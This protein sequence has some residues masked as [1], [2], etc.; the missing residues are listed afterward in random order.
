[1]KCS[2]VMSAASLRTMVTAM[3]TWI[4]G[5]LEVADEFGTAFVYA[6]LN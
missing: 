1:V 3:L 5:L 6:S 2:H 4:Q